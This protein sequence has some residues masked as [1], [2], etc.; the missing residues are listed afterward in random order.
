MSQRREMAMAKVPLGGILGET[1]HTG[2]VVTS[3]S[4]AEQVARSS[5][6]GP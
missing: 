4:I 3:S 6:V 1:R 5:R 2:G